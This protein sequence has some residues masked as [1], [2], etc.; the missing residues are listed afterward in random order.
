MKGS[1]S[2]VE[3]VVHVLREGGL[4]VVWVSASLDLSAQ[5]DEFDRG[6]PLD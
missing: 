2:T 5:I 6:F 4:V 3:L 1:L